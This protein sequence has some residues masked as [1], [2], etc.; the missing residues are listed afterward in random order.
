[1]KPSTSILAASALASQA[2]AANT[3]TLFG[4]IAD[5]NVNRTSLKHI[6]PVQD[7]TILYANNITDDNSLV[8]ITLS[9]SYP[10]VVLENVDAVTSVDCSDDSVTVTFNNTAS[11]LVT[12]REWSADG[13][14]VIITNHLGDCDAEIER[15]FFLVESLSWDNYTLAVTA[16]SSRAN[17]TD[18]AGMT[19]KSLKS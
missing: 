11:Y 5:A 1:M 2:V 8:N 14:F 7:V 13:D 19:L 18:T 15:G 4:P 17:I 9:M 3:T 10:T 12:T 16:S 6:T